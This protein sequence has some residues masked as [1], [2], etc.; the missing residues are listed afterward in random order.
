MKPR[1]SRRAFAAQALAITE[2]DAN[3]VWRRL[4]LTKYP[5]PLGF[6]YALS[7]FSDPR[8]TA[9]PPVRFGVVYLGRSVKVCFAEA[10]QRDRAVG[11]SG[12]FPI[13]YAELEDWTCAEIAVVARLKLVDLRGDGVIRMGIPTDVAQAKSHKLGQ[14]WSRRIWEHPDKVDGI[15][16]ASRLNGETNI[17]VYDRALAKLASVATPRL[18]ECRNEL[19]EIIDAFDLAIV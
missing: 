8:L 9:K 6:G 4:Y 17:A 15:I 13:E 3:D 16:Y 19:A 11:R 2:I 18:I 5:N 12:S 14:T 1:F 10:I 7:R